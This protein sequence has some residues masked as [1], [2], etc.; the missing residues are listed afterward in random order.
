MGS[1]LNPVHLPSLL[2][3]TGGMRDPLAELITRAKHLELRPARHQLLLIHLHPSSA[4]R[5][6]VTIRLGWC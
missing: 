1:G 2:C 4:S 5:M 6:A 3:R